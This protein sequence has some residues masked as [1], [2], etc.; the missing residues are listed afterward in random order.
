MGALKHVLLKAPHG[1]LRSVTLNHY[2]AVLLHFCQ[3][4]GAPRRRPRALRGAHQAEASGA[5]LML[6]SI[7]VT[8]GVPRPASIKHARRLA[9]CALRALSMLRRRRFRH[10]HGVPNLLGARAGAV[11]EVVQQTHMEDVKFIFPQFAKRPELSPG[12]TLCGRTLLFLLLA[13]C[14]LATAGGHSGAPSAQAQSSARTLYLP[15]QRR[16]A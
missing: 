16:R 4:R 11:L 9:S 6:R 1:A 12:E 13:C 15:A 5:T 10:P 3:Q 7:S 14:L 2:A 8:T